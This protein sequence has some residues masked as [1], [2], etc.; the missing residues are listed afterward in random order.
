[1]DMERRSSLEELMK[2]MAEAS[3]YVGLFPEEAARMGRKSI[4]TNSPEPIAIPHAWEY[5]KVREF[6][7]RIS[8]FLSPKESERRVIHLVNPGLRETKPLDTIAVTPTMT[9]GFQLIKA[10]ESAPSHRHTP[11]NLRLILEA[12]ES[13]AYII[14]DGF[15][16]EVKVGDVLV[17]SNWALHEHHNE[18]PSDLIWLSGLDS[19]LLYYLGGVFYSREKWEGSST[20]AGEVLEET[21]GNSL[22]PISM[23]A[24]S[25]N[26]LIRY[27]YHRVIR[28][29]E[30]L[31]SSRGPDPHEGVAVELT[32]PRDGGPALP[33]ISMR[34][35][36]IPGKAE[37]RPV[38]RV[39]NA[40]LVPVEGSITVEVSDSPAG[41]FLFKL[42]STI[43]QLYPRGRNSGS[44]TAG[45]PLRSSSSTQ[46]DQSSK[47]WGYSGRSCP[48]SR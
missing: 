13:G 1:M 35:R 48:E 39:E 25:W 46:T 17:Q 42:S 26:P 6:L 9:C 5:G 45:K 11:V 14:Y 40:V 32:N 15:K 38:R 33:T 31:D 16:V 44:R 8:G 3:V 34:M 22:K 20:I 7:Y 10:G 41:N 29:L 23:K 18:G 27:P 43:P 4:F 12:P 28:A 47:P 36:M 24:Y 2:S 37:L 19:P 21:Y 30:R